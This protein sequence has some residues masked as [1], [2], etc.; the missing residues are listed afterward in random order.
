MLTFSLRIEARP[1]KIGR[2]DS[3]TLRSRLVLEDDKR[4]WETDLVKYCLPSILP[5]GYPSGESRLSQVPQGR[6]GMGFATP[7]KAPAQVADRQT[8]KEEIVATRR[9]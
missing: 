9:V 3:L 7:S 4:E 2:L 5:C 1:G 8:Q 6:L